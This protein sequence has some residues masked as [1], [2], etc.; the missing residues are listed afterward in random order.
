MVV[1]RA[2]EPRDTASILTIYAPHVYNS[3]VS[4]EEFLPEK[5]A[6]EDRLIRI[7]A[8]YPFYVLEENNEILG[9]AYASQHRERVAYRWIVETTIYMRDSARGKGLGKLLYKKLLD[10]LVL[11]NFTLAYGIIT[12]PNDAS[13]HLHKSC[14]FENLVVHENAGWK[15]RQ[16]NDVLWMKKVLNAP[17]TPPIEPIWKNESFTF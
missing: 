2:F 8:K 15:N 10:E 16:W 3:A 14:G 7:D 5:D 12:I 4:F 1:I 11:R 17:A 9:Y 6:F 13:I